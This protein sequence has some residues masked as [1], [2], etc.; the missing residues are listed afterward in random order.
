MF[1]I[2]MR[3]PSQVFDATSK[4]TMNKDTGSWSIHCQNNEMK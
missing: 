4:V 2:D 1:L 3:I